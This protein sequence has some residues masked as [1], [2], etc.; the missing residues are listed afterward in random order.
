MEYAHGKAHQLGCPRGL[1]MPGPF[2]FTIKKVSGKRDV[3]D[4]KYWGRISEFLL[5]YRPLKRLI[6]H[7]GFWP[8]TANTYTV[9][10]NPCYRWHT[11]LLC[12]WIM[13]RDNILSVLDVC[14]F[15]RQINCVPWNS[16]VGVDP[17]VSQL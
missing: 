7:M 9:V 8:S 2:L 5:C 1:P 3:K 6:H 11:W 15:H 14:L 13:R 17:R 4:H 12:V 16:W 10:K